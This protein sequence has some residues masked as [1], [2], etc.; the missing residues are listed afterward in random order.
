MT[1]NEYW[2]FSFVFATASALM[3]FGFSWTYCIAHYG[4]LIGVGSGWVPALIVGL[5]TW[6]AVYLLWPVMVIGATV[7]VV[8]G[9]GI[10]FH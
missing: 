2:F 1:D 4:F 9:T 7:F 3:A 10:I 6:I 8:F 5:C